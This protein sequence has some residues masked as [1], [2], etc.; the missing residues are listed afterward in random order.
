MSSSS[1]IFDIFAKSPLKP[2]QAHMELAHQSCL[3]LQP[4]FAAVI[5]QDWPSVEKHFAHIE[6]LEH[7]A[8]DIK[9]SLKLHLTKDLF[10]PV[11]R[12]N[13]LQ[14]LC[15]QEELVNRAEDIS[16]LT[17][18]RQL[19]IPAPLTDIFTRFLNRCIDAAQQANQATLELNELAET[20]FQGNA[21]KIVAQMIV[22]LD[23]IE[24]DTDQL[25]VATRKSLATIEQD[26]PPIDIIFLYK[27]IDWIGE[28][29]DFA[30]SAG[31][32]LQLLIAR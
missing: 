22:K 10:L 19:L 21:T 15:I 20:G 26:F 23:E 27:I 2:L 11:S 31:A 6:K 16:G 25:Q 14:L 12:N 3:A 30:Q 24:R 18:G 9:R 28:L 5:A 1:A 29:A 13:I 32:R 8:D 4:F 7:D 17:L